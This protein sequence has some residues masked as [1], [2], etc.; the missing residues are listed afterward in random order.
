MKKTIQKP[1]NWQDF[2]SLCKK[3]WGEIW[4]IPTRIKKNGRSGQPQSGVD[5]Y[6]IPEGE[7]K[8][9][10]IQCKGK[11]DYSN[12]KLTK[13]EIDDEISK[14]MTFKPELAVFTFA[15]TMNK[16]SVIEEYVRIKNIESQKQGRFEILLYCW[17]D[18]CDL[19]EENRD[20]YN[21]YVNDRQHKAKYGFNV[22]LNE[23]M[24]ELVIKP[25]CVCKIRKY[26]LKKVEDTRV[27]NCL[28]PTLMNA[29][30]VMKYIDFEN[31]SMASILKP[32]VNEAIC[33]FE[34]IMENTGS[35][36]I[37][38]WKVQLKIIGEHKGITDQL[39][40]GILGLD[41]YPPLSNKR[42]YVIGNNIIYEPL[43]NQPLIQKD[44]RYFKAFI[45]PECKEYSIPIEWELLAR[46]YDTRG[47]VVLKVEPIV[48]DQ[49][50]YKDV[51]TTE[52][53]MEDEIISIEAKKNY[54]EDSEK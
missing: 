53:L 29:V 38:D 37:E 16:D 40:D 39:R 31:V 19:I 51:D 1:E 49:F 52:E 26:R 28:S 33:E 5:I 4:D 46:D 35:V 7:E 23:F 47:E 2:E 36:V 41:R 14:A 25:K 50:I 42:T 11:D 32:R 48:E 54:D 30:T 15:T 17:E 27:A 43:E 6:G 44:N 45:I 10:G 22:Y 24:P 8:Y 12:A 13:K 18:I 20:T 21:F 34:I 3:L 9:W